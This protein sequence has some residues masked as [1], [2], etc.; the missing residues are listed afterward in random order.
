MDSVKF[1]LGTISALLSFFV[2]IFVQS[3]V[4]FFQDPV[5]AL[6]ELGVFIVNQVIGGLNLI[7]LAINALIPGNRFDIGLAPQLDTEEVLALYD[8]AKEALKDSVDGVNGASEEMDNLRPA[9]SGLKGKVDGAVDS[10]ANALDYI[11]DQA[12][13]VSRSP[14]GQLSR[15]GGSSTA[16]NLIGAA[17]RQSIDP[18]FAEAQR[19]NTNKLLKYIGG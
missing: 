12:N 5:R 17:R 10:L 14:S 7:I 4:S 18:V 19:Q 1:I 2:I 3:V 11:S 13:A 16:F 6:I 8:A 15:T 9:I